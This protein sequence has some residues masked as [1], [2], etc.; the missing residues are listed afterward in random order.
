[1]K[2]GKICPYCNKQMEIDEIKSYSENKT[3][4]NY[5]CKIC[6]HKDYDLY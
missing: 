2:I 1:M 5:Y 6:E 4:I 3:I